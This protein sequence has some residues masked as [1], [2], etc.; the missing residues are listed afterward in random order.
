MNIIDEQMLFC[1]PLMDQGEDAPAIDRDGEAG[2]TKRQ[3]RRR[4]E[5]GERLKLAGRCRLFFAFVTMAAGMNEKM[6]RNLGT[7]R[8]L[9]PEITE[10]RSW[11]RIFR[12]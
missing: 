6:R 11:G 9:D 12:N 3:G 2:K 8:R 10:V 5:R 4:R 1:T 7:L